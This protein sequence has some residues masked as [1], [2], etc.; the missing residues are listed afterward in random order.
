MLYQRGLADELKH[1]TA[2]QAFV[3]GNGLLNLNQIEYNEHTS[4]PIIDQ[5]WEQ[6][7]LVFGLTEEGLKKDLGVIITDPSDRARVEA[8]LNNKSSGIAKEQTQYIQ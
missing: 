4:Q 3:K 1:D 2:F 6:Y 7:D 8:I 5:F